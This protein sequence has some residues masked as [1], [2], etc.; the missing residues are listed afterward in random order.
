MPASFPDLKPFFS[1]KSAALVGASADLRKFGG[2][3]LKQLVDFGYEGRIYPV[4]PKADTI[5]GMP[6]YPDIASLPEAPDHVGIVVPGKAIPGVLKQC[7]DRGV[8]HVT[9]FSSGFSEGGSADGAAFQAEI[10]ALARE[11]GIRLMGPNCNGLINYVDGFAL[12]S[13]ATIS[14]PRAPKGDVAVLGHSGGLAQVNVMYRAQQAGLGI[15]YQVSCGNDADLDILDYAAFMVDDPETRVI[16]MLAE[17]I[18]DGGKL[19]ALSDRARAAGKPIVMMKLGRSEEGMQAAVSHTGAL[20]SSDSVADDVLRQL[21]ILRVDDCHEMIDVAM[22]LRTGRRLGGR[23]LAA[24]SISGGNL[25]HLAD[26]GPMHGLAF[27]DFGSA[28]KTRMAELIPNYGQASN[29]A[30]VTSAAIGSPEIFAGVLETIAQD[31]A[32]DVILPVL[33]LHSAEL[34]RGTAQ[35]LLASPKPC[36]VIWSGNCTDDDTLTHAELVRM[37][38]P[39]FRDISPAMQVIDAAAR[40]AEL[41]QAARPVVAPVSPVQGLDT[42]PGQPDEADAKAFLAANG[43]DVPRGMVAETAA[44]AGP[45]ADRLGG[46]VAV[47]ILSAEIGH[48][49]ELGGVQLNLNG[50]TASAAA[51]EMGARIREAAPDHELRGFLIEEMAAPGVEMILGLSRDPVFGMVLTV[52]LGGIMAELLEDV[53]HRLLPVSEDEALSMLR[54]LRGWPLLDGH[55]GRAPADVPALVRTITTLSDLGMGSD[56]RIETLDLNPVIVGGAGQG[57][58]V[59]DALVVRSR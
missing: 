47:K 45:L 1:P 35:A 57:A 38:L 16:L 39:V 2:R 6:C 5:L 54:Q 22:M 29:P 14:G 32:V 51:E 12:T 25:V 46:A 30:D 4:N 24:V 56:G 27:P 34:I 18:R 40:Y 20:A 13:T 55:R 26:Q 15:S 36:A 9:I 37:G 8:R 28:T 53:A 10:V 48:K 19:R 21:G 3:C 50:A 11:H 59:C 41:A 7:G 58:T 17:T 33:T 23:G 49:T 52:G 42:L 44:D 43:F 31:P